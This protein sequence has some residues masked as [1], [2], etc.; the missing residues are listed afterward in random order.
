MAPQKRQKKSMKIL[1]FGYNG[2]IVRRNKT[3]QRLVR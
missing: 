2:W 3:P 1:F